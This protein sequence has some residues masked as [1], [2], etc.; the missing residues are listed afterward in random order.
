MPIKHRKLKL[1]ADRVKWLKGRD[2]SLRGTPT[3][4]NPQVVNTLAGDVV[5]MVDK[6]NL[7][8]SNQLNRLFATPAAK[9]SIQ[10]TEKVASLEKIGMV[11][12]AAMDR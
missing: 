10:K 2:T 1:S 3:R 12:G 9:N 5:K 11:P 4:I 6:M 8:V 7:D